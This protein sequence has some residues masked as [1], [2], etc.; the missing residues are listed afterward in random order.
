MPRTN[1]V[2]LNIIDFIVIV[3]GLRYKTDELKDV[4]IDFIDS[5]KVELYHQ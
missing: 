2:E 3:S 4:V 5:K 1:E